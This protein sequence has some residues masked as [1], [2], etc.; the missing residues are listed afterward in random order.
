MSSKKSMIAIALLL[1]IQASPCKSIAMI[2][3]FL[4]QQTIL[5]VKLF[6]TI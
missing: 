3:S 1:A 6:W 4:Q 5:M 2:K